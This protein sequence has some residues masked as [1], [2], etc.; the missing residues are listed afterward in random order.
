MLRALYYAD[1]ADFEGKRRPGSYV[2]EPRGMT[3]LFELVYFCPCGCGMQNRLL[4]GEGH[5]PG[6]PRPSWN[7]NGSRTEPELK[8][9]V[10]MTGHWHGYLRDGYWETV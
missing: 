1:K 4:V 9:S 5:K 2:V 3:G 10:N 7:W 8:P 6:G